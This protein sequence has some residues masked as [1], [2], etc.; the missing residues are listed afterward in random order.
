M[1]REL[2]LVPLMVASAPARL[3]RALRP[4]ATPSAAASSA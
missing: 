1:A 4:Q 2:I 3:D